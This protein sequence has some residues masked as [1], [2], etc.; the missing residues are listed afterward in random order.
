VK[1]VKKKLVALSLLALLA[2]CGG[3]GGGRPSAGDLAKALNDH[4]NKVGAQ[5]T[6]AF[7]NPDADTIDCIAKVLH[8]SKVSDDAL[9]AIVDA[10]EDY[11]GSDKDSEAFQDATTGMAKCIT[12]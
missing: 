1:P 11:K 10:N 5:F 6:E 8:E 9:Q 3:G 4:D 2:A 12:G 7:Q